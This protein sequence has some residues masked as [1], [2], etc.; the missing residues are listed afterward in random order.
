MLQLVWRKIINN[1]W[2]V[3]CLLTGSILAVGMVC[4]IPIYSDG[5][6]QRMLIKDLENAQIRHNLYPG[7]LAIDSDFTY[8][9]K[10]TVLDTAERMRRQMASFQQTMP[11]GTVLN[12]EINRIERLFYRHQANNKTYSTSIVLASVSDFADH[13]RITN[14]RLYR[15]DLTG[16]VVETVVSAAALKYSDMVMDRE[17]EIFSYGQADG[18]PSLLKV[19]VVGVYEAADFQ[20]LYW[21]RNTDYFRTALMVSPDVL[22]TL[23]QMDSNLLM[24]DQMLVSA[25]DYHDFRVTELDRLEAAVKAG[26]DFEDKNL[27]TS[28]FYSTFEKVIDGYTER[29]N[30]LKLTLQILIIPILLMLV[31]YIFMVSQLMIRS[32]TAVISVLESRGAGRAQILLLYGLESLLLGLVAMLAGPSLGLWMVRIIG[33]SNGFLEFVSRKALQ[34]GIGGQAIVFGVIAVIL[35]I[36]TTLLPVLIQSRTS[37]VRQKQK[38]SR[39]PKAPFWQRFYLD[40]ILLAISLYAYYRLNVQV[41][42]QKSTGIARPGSEMDMLLFVA[43]TLFILGAGLLFLRFYPLLMQLIYWLGKRF[44][45]PALYASFHQISRSDGQEQFLMIFLILALSIGLFN[46]NAARTINQNIEDTIYCQVGSDIRLQEFWQPY[47]VQG[48]PIVT[49]SSSDF[50]GM[51]DNAN[52]SK[53]IKYFEPDLQKY[54]KLAGVEHATRVLQL[55]DMR[56]RSAAGP[57][58]HIGLMGID[59]YEFALTAWTRNDM[60]HYSINEYMN[61]MSTMPNAVILSANLK[62]PLELA[63]G[64]SIIYTVNKSD[65][66]EGIIIAFVDYWPGYQPLD[67]AANGTVTQNSLIIG[68][69]DYILSKTAIQPYEIWIRR[70]EGMTDKEI[71]SALEDA[72]IS[73]TSISSANQLIAAAKNDPQLQGTNGALTLGFIVSMLICAIGF[74]IYWIISI[75]SRVLQ[76]GVYRAMGLGRAP[77]IGMLVSEQIMV[78]GVAIGF[79]IILGTLSSRLFVPLFQLVYSSADQPLPFLTIALAADSQKVLIVLSILL[80]ICF[81]ILA[82]LILR[83]R[84]AQAVKLG[85]E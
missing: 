44:W 32:E 23:H 11:I 2:K 73:V 10:G 58:N 74:L 21:F 18:Q 6:M 35:I 55:D 82:R 12:S 71:Y 1:A 26:N 85:E 53:I 79:G 7:Y 33:S 83:I 78:S 43:S 27:K 30:E 84:I 38:T 24:T 70:V 56:I 14:G 64:D 52:R 8:I 48:Q 72:R 61:V 36:L 57:G 81:A 37:I 3:I 45:N 47:D 49:V 4:S 16:G 28:K 68:N 42:L 17:Y 77:L 15:T 9:E 51:L 5:I 75:Q 46:A 22:P 19:K 54:S 80:V 63:V 40:I 67:I 39:R 60:N 69:L 41:E 65:I 59:P 34:T 50:S 25:Y 76:F 31:F 13:I 62:D 20:D 66:A 29:E